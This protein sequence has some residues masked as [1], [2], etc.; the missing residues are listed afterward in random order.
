MQDFHEIRL[1]DKFVTLGKSKVHYLVGGK[2]EDPALL[3]LHGWASKASIFAHLGQHLAQDHYVIIPDL[4]G[5]GESATLEQA[6]FLELA[7][8]TLA[9]LDKLEVPSV[10]IVS[11]SMGGGVGVEM[12]LLAPKR[13]EKL[14]LLSSAL[15]PIER[16]LWDWVVVN[17]ETARRIVNP[18]IFWQLTK[19]F[20]TLCENLARHP[21]W[22]TSTF[23]LSTRSDL[24]ADLRKIKVTPTVICT[25]DETEFLPA[26]NQV[27]QILTIEPTLIKGPGHNWPVLEPHQATEIIEQYV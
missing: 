4:P 10:S 15:N 18:K 11:H 22:T 26:I 3:I 7:K 27:C 13:V 8:T 23:Y 16:N 5:C 12:A 24:L 19:V 1:Q 17:F 9:L 20:L 6:N 2:K 14:L 21:L 25:S